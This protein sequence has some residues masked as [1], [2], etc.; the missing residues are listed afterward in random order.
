MTKNIK[1]QVIT[2]ANLGGIL[3]DRSL[4]TGLKTPVDTIPSMIMAINGAIS[5][6]ASRMA[7]QNSTIKKTNT[8]FW[9]IF[10]SKILPMSTYVSF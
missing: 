5:L 1:T 8:A 10:C 9:E 6:P 2:D 4:N 3:L 7:M